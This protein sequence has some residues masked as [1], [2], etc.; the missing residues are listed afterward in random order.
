MTVRNL[1]YL[2]EPAS[3]ALIGASRRPNAPGTRLL[4]NLRAAGYGGT[5]YAVNPKYDELD[6]LRCYPDVASLPVT[7]ELAVIV[8]PAPT[9][10]RLVKQLAERGCRAAVVVSGGLSSDTG[11][12]GRRR[13]L[14][15]LKVARPSRFRL[16]G[17]ES[18][19]LIVPP[20]GLNASCAHLT[21]KPG[22]LALVA[23][24]GAVLTAMIDWAA[25]KDIGFSKL[26][27]LGAKADVDFGDVLNYLADDRGTDAVLLYIESIQHARKFMSAARAAARVKPVIVLKAGRG[28]V[29]PEGALF[30]ADQIYNAAF[31]RAGLLRVYSVAEL[32]D[33]AELLAHSRLLRGSRLAILTNSGAMG[34]LAED[35]LVGGGGRL[36]ELGA[37]SKRLL[38]A[39]PGVRESSTNLIDVATDV[40]PQNYAAA[41]RV[42]LDE[43]AVDAVLAVHCP[44]AG[45]A[46]ET[47]AES[48]I[49]AAAGQRKL[50]LVSWVGSATQ[51]SSRTLFADHHIPCY[52]SPDEAT[53]AF[54]QLMRYRRNQELLIETPPTVS[55][56]FNCDS[57]AAGRI[58]DGALAD[59]RDWLLGSEVRQLMLAYAIPMVATEHA[60][61][62]EQAAAAAAR[63]RE[64]VALKIASPDI[65]YKSAVG[66]VILD[67]QGPDQVEVVALG[68]HELMRRRFPQARIEGFTVQP[69]VRWPWALELQLGV[70]ADALFGPLLIF[71]HGGTAAEALGDRAVALPPLNLKLAH[72][73]IE[74]TRVARLLAGYRGQPPADVEAVALCLIKLSQLVADQDRLA[75]ITINPLLVSA[76]GVLVMDARVRLSREP[77]SGA[78]RLAIR[79]YPTTLE[80]SL[81]LPDGRTLLLRPIR[82]EDEP[83][84]QQFVE[85][86]NPEEIRLRFHHPLK[87]MD[88]KLAARL[89]QLDY[90]REMA[91][92]LTDPAGAI[93]AVVRFSAD[94]D[95]RCAEYAIIV[96]HELAGMGLGLLL[97]QR[98]I[99]YARSQ[100]VG[101][102]YG[103]VLRENE[104]MLGL[105]RKLGFLLER[106]PDGAGLVLAR[107]PL[108]RDNQKA[109]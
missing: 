19:G 103:S 11:R 73:L 39:V 68:M 57:A 75:A 77:V 14:V 17:P 104:A 3:V 79:P 46:S 90:D 80:E 32:F 82:A 91:L 42:L 78:D 85:R 58:I 62:A 38:Q 50:L 41:L 2:F 52:A 54:L 16:L 101:E 13:G 84:L 34:A 92:A 33:M 23:Q 61:D 36:A 30:G 69:M 109:V 35:V 108:S 5:L 26:V 21:P 20:I 87:V 95:R 9:V 74:R 94:P 12:R 15:M 56:R 51:G 96:G 49:D 107:L 66:G 44:V 22:R 29:V 72:E 60:A 102:L 99:D 18:L 55:D 81:D 83:A 1:R 27:S 53:Q 25:D 7:P 86:L 100:S 64:P 45:I 48:V 37:D 67:L 97:M 71:G 65:A 43:R 88:H 10:A 93:H 63:L 6:G 40:E 105:C 28:A 70:M 89:T 76:R 24:S 8:T 31:E 98:I 59:G 106:H 4:A 47:V